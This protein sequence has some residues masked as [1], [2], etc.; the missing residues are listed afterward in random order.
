[1]NNRVDDESL[2]AW[3]VH[4]RRIAA[5]LHLSSDHVQV[6]M[7]YIHDHDAQ[8]NA[9]YEAIV[10]R[11]EQGKPGSGRRATASQP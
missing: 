8:V 1:V 11:I 4:L 7:D 3:R 9:E 2:P 5:L 10:A 6:A